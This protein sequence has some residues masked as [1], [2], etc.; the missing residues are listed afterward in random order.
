MGGDFCLEDPWANSYTTW[1]KGAGIIVQDNEGRLLIVKDRKSG[2]WSFP[3]G[4]PEAWDHDKTILTAIR[5]CRE[6]VGLSEG[7]DYEL[8]SFVPFAFSYDRYFYPAKLLR[9][10]EL[11]AQDEEIVA[12]E[13]MPPHIIREQ[14]ND[15]NSGVRE[16]L[17]RFVPRGY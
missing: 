12:M 14:W 2:K 8:T 9:K 13:W 17:R 10:V 11:I 6:E 3:K 5:E 15:L 4:A 1:Y 7:L 16:Y